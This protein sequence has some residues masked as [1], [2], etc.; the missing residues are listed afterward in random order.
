[1]TAGAVAFSVNADCAGLGRCSCTALG[2][3]LEVCG[4]QFATGDLEVDTDGSLKSTVK[5][6]TD[7]GLLPGMGIHLGD[8][9]NAAYSFTTAYDYG[10]ARVLAF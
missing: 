10:F 4:F 9:S 3:T 1:M 5:D 7:F 6:F 8:D 2:A